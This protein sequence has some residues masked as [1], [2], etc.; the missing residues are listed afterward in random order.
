MYASNFR[1]VNSHERINIPGSLVS[2]IVIPGFLC[3][4]RRLN[5]SMTQKS[6]MKKTEIASPSDTKHSDLAPAS[7]L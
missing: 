2:L 4:C 5:E 3:R 6:T 7:S 1:W